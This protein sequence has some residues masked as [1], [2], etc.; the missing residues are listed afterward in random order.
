MDEF[1]K[2]A[3]IMMKLN[4]VTDIAETMKNIEYDA[5]WTADRFLQEILETFESELSYAAENME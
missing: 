1:E 4:D 3:D 2:I 5:S